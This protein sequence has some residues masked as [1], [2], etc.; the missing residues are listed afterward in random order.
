[1]EIEPRSATPEVNWTYE[2]AD[3]EQGGYY[4]IGMDNKKMAVILPVDRTQPIDAPGRN[5]RLFLRRYGKDEWQER[6]PYTLREA[7]ERGND[8]AKFYEIEM[9]HNAYL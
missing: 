1:M 5:A 9:D 4:R 7:C 8:H 2:K 6:G 3:L